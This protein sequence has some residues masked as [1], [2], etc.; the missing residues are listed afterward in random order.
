MKQI[1]QKILGVLIIIVLVMSFHQSFAVTQSE[2]NSQKN[3]QTQNNN[4]INDVEKKKDEVEAQKSAVQKEVETL[5]TQIN[6]YEDQIDELDSKINEANNKINEAENR[7]TQA[8]NNYDKKQ[9]ILEKRIV[10]VYEAGET[11]YLDVLLNSQSVTE[12]ISKYYIVSEVAEHD[13]EL[14][15]EIQTQKQE[16]ET[17]KQ[18]LEKSKEELTTAKSSKTS[19]ANELKTAKS[20]KDA[21]VAQLSEEE[22]KLEAEIQELQVANR[23]LANQIKEAERKYA[24]QL[25]ALNNGSS[26]GSGGGSI[27]PTGSGYLMR[28]ISGGS[29]S[30]NGYYPSGRFHGAIDYAVSEGTPVYAAADGVVMLTANLTSSYGTHVVI[31]HGNGLQTYYAHGTRGSICVSSGQIVKKGQQIMRS[32]NTGNSSGPHLHFEVRVSP[33]N[34]NGYATRYGQDSRVNPNNYM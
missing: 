30:A 1:C 23:Q 8:Q 3:Q 22:K 17:A 4:K 25:A 26:S 10:A 6:Y 11:S 21:K 31:R 13:V 27:P 20:Q 28:P 24:E 5:S 34:Y 29:I 9:E 14:L 7:I 2:I 19:V 16:I 32:G 18:D 33:Y 15:N 12:F